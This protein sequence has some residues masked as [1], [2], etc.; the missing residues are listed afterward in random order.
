MALPTDSSEQHASSHHSTTSDQNADIT[1]PKPAA[2]SS[3][4]AKPSADETSLASGTSPDNAHPVSAERGAGGGPES[5]VA[6]SKDSG[7]QG[8]KEKATALYKWLHDLLCSINDGEA[9]SD[10]DK[11]KEITAIL[12]RD[13]GEDR[14]N[15]S[16]Y[17][18]DHPTELDVAVGLNSYVAAEFLLKNWKDVLKKALDL[19]RPLLHAAYSAENQD[20]IRLLVQHRA[21]INATDDNG[22]TVLD[23]ACYDSNQDM[24]GV[25]LSLHAD[26]QVVDADKWSPLH[27]AAFRGNVRI[28][29]MLLKEDKANINHTKTSGETALGLAIKFSHKEFVQVLLNAGADCNA[30]TG[31]EGTTPLMEAVIQPEIDIAKA[32]LSAE[33]PADIDR[34]GPQ[35]RTALHMAANNDMSNMVSF[36]LEK[37]ADA[38]AADS[39]GCIPLHLAS[40]EGH[41][42]VINCLLQNLGK[43]QLKISDKNGHTA[44]MK[45]CQAESNDVIEM[46]L[47]NFDDIYS[48]LK[49]LEERDALRWASENQ[50]RH[51]LAALLLSKGPQPNEDLKKGR[52]WSAIEWAAY[53]KNAPV[54]WLLL[55]NSYPDEQTETCRTA[56]L[57]I[58]TQA[59]HR[60]AQKPMPS[61]PPGNSR[62][63]AYERAGGE[64]AAPDAK[65]K[66]SGLQD[67][68][69]DIL[70]DPPNMYY[71]G[72]KPLEYPSHRGV[73]SELLNSYDATIAFFSSSQTDSGMLERFRTV[74]DVIYDRGPTEIYNSSIKELQNLRDRVKKQYG[75][76]SLE[77]YGIPKQ[78]VD[79][80]KS[81]LI[82]VHLP[83]T[84]VSLYEPVGKNQLTYSR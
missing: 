31:D 69:K 84:N 19:Q 16:T 82:W 81:D 78:A 40:A 18:D 77:A 39:D 58:A 36:L 27:S 57:D 52:T 68:I 8:G 26:T 67:I 42:D 5:G 13:G 71:Q 66:D 41:V 9:I 29:E 50:G 65:S 83:A 33:Y 53:R 11:E 12:Q 43:E 51:D 2:E 74:K 34:R 35:K 23:Y 44:I 73:N 54:L 64:N 17:C 76:K 21:D 28:A 56:A 38:L 61:Q 20:L 75:E 63:Y 45:A 48:G 80:Q 72:S 60:Q 6:S 46:L 79:E 15:D 14:V 47:K 4:S 49:E 30:V 3:A 25:L 32:L 10:D 1:G 62:K 7:G 22:R 59:I 24:V 70:S 37:G 55:V